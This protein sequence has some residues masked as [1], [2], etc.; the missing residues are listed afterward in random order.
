MPTVSSHR[1]AELI[2]IVSNL[3]PDR[4]ADV[5]AAL[6]D[7]RR[8]AE[9]VVEVDEAAR[10]RACPHCGGTESVRWGTTRTGTH[11]WRCKG[12][13]RTWTGRTGTP[14][15]RIHRP[16]LMLDLI[17]D[18]MGDA[19]HSCRK[20][21]KALGISRHTA[22]RWRMLVLRR[23]DARPSGPLQGIVETDD[24]GHRESRKGSREWVRHLRCQTPTAPPRR[25]WKGW[26]RRGPPHAVVMAWTENVLA[27]TDRS[28]T[29]ALDH[30]PDK[31]QR[32]ID[33]AL[34]PRVAEDAMLLFDGAPQEAI[35]GAGAGLQRPLR[36]QAPRDDA[37]RLP[38]QHGERPP[39]VLE[40]LLAAVLWAGQQEPRRPRPVVRRPTLGT[41]QRLPRSAFFI[42]LSTT[43][44]IC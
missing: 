14:I 32:S 29:A 43:N 35:E 6:G 1:L 34:V 17:R 25:R 44:T 8:R 23:L 11:R 18:M 15:A 31:S 10:G 37:G 3:P 22:W 13:G 39:L 28:G 2:D 21:A 27:T 9:A 16:G 12:C 33:A 36:G 5:E 42:E 19:P 30:L 41:S 26:G 38:P 4:I 7:A 40:G 20:L 24:T